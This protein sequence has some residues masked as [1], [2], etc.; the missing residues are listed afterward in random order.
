MNIHKIIIILIQMEMDEKN[1][2]KLKMDEKNIF[3]RS[4]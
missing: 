4:F 2:L 3:L 1:I